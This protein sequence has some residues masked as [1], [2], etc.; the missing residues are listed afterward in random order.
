[1][2]IHFSMHKTFQISHKTKLVF[3]YE[4]FGHPAEGVVGQALRPQWEGGPN[5][6]Q[7]Q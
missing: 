5:F 6:Q 3:D 7:P 2:V 1:M 4:E